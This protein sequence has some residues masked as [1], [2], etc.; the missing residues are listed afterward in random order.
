MAWYETVGIGLF[1]TGTFDNFVLSEMTKMMRKI[2]CLLFYSFPCDFR[3]IKI[4]I[5]YFS[6][7]IPIH[8]VRGCRKRHPEPSECLSSMRDHIPC[9][10]LCLGNILWPHHVC[11]ADV[12]LSKFHATQRLLFNNLYCQ[13]CRFCK[14]L[15]S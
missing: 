1:F 5:F 15:H 11:G 4:N 14:Q 2:I 7:E 3:W 12:Y 10:I 13:D 9:F 6:V 8:N